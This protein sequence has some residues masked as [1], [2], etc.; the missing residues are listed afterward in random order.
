MFVNLN[1][2]N[3]ELIKYGILKQMCKDYYAWLKPI[4]KDRY[5]GHDKLYN[6][7]CSRRRKELRSIECYVVSEDFRQLFNI[8]GPLILQKVRLMYEM[9]EK[10]VF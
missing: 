8:D 1:E 10:L 3:V 2:D 6:T 5:I 4:N 7:M 9:G